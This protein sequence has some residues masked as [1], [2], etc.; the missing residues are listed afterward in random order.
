MPHKSILLAS[1]ENKLSQ[2]VATGDNLVVILIMGTLAMLVMA[3]FII[4]IILLYQKK[5]LAQKSQLQ[6]AET[7]Y[8]RELVRAAILVEDR[9]RERFAKNLHDDVG[10]LLTVA[11]LNLAS[12][13]LSAGNSPREIAL[14][15]SSNTALQGITTTV[16]EVSRDLFPSRLKTVGYHAAVRQMAVRISEGGLIEANVVQEGPE[17]KYEQAT[18]LQLYRITQE[19]LNNILKHSSPKE[20]YIEFTGPEKISIR[21]SGKGISNEDAELLVKQGKG[22]GLQSIQ[23]RAQMINAGVDYYVHGD[24]DA[25]AVISLSEPKLVALEV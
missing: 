4:L 1:T 3:G 25:E 2:A 17:I 7:K 8:Q 13:K 12:E 20:I 23:S 6:E 18:E 22:I 10:S 15:D 21:Y 5:V 11:M 19:L 14:I 16:R 9:A 24:N